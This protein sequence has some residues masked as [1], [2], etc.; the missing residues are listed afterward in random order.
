MDVTLEL[1]PL[2]AAH[3]RALT[4]LSDPDAEVGD[5]TSV[6]ESDPALTAAILRAANSAASAPV[7]HIEVVD[8]AVIRMGLSLT[9]RLIVSAVASNAFGEL[10]RAGIDEGETWRHLVATARPGGVVAVSPRSGGHHVAE[11]T[12]P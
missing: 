5:F 6:V 3:G 7:D 10:E 9:R 11:V 12:P 8:V 1:P 4:L 2:S